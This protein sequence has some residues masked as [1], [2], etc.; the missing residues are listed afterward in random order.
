[1]SAFFRSLC[2]SFPLPPF[3]YERNV[4]LFTGVSFFFL[5]PF[6]LGGPLCNF[7]VNLQWNITLSGTISQ[8]QVNFVLYLNDACE[9]ARVPHKPW[10]EL[11]QSLLCSL[12]NLEGVFILI[13]SICWNHSLLF[14]L[15][16]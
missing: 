13:V 12:V 15:N 1:M 9:R 10:M 16:K 5:N 7:M 3:L 14:Y 8:H 6:I 2:L 11:K 4:F